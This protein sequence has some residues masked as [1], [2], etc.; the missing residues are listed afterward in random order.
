M[1]G[2]FPKTFFQAATSC[3]GIFL[4]GNFPN[5]QFSK[6]QFPK[7]VIATAL[8]PLA[9][10]SRSAQPPSLSL[11][12][13]RA[14]GPRGPNLSFGKLPLEKMNIWEVAIGKMP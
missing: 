14:L 2:T 4:S 6:L 5:L 8:G 7:Y 13:P 12:Q 1:L 11:P 9:C 10:S 3:N